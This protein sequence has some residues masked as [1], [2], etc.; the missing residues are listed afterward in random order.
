MNY[1]DKFK[2][3]SYFTIDYSDLDEI[4]SAEYGE[5]DFTTALGQSNDSTL[6]FY[7]DG[8]FDYDEVEAFIKD[9]EFD[10]YSTTSNLLNHL[11]AKDKIDAG[12]YL[13][14]ICW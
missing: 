10:E 6:E 4:I 14:S 9:K 13:I 12:F 5:S 8:T 2:K 1:Q 3:E 11:C 7:I